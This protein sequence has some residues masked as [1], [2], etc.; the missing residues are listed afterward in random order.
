M[1][2][3]DRRFAF[4]RIRPHPVPVKLSRAK[5]WWLA[6]ALLVVLI[7]GFAWLHRRPKAMDQRLAR[8]RAAGL[9]A[10]LAE[11][12]AWYRAVPDAENAAPELLEAI[13]AW[14]HLDSNTPV[15]PANGSGHPNPGA[16]WL[17]SAGAELT[18]NA[19]PLAQIHAALERPRS[20]YP[21]NLQAGA[22]LSFSH[23]APAKQ[24]AQQL[25]SEARFA[26]E[27]GDPE[28]AATALLATLRT[29]R[30]LEEEPL[31]ISYLVRLADNAIAIDAT[32]AVISRGPLSESGLHRLQQAFVAAESTNHLA[33]AIA[34]E[35][36]LIL[37]ALNQP[38]LK[39]FTAFAAPGNSSPQLFPMIFARLYDL[40]GLKGD[41]LGFCLDRLDDLANG[42]ARPRSE[43]IAPQ[44][45]L[46]AQ[47]DSLSSWRGRLRPLSR[48]TLPAFVKVLGKDLRSVATLRCAQTALAIERWRLAH[49]GSLP[50][51]LNALVPEYLAAVPEDPMDGKPLKY[52]V[53][54]PGYVV[55]S[56]G[57]DGTD[58]GGKERVPGSGVTKGWDYTF[59]VA[60]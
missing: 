60:R 38:A 22:A 59:T 2:S 20:R 19:V 11:L 30:T 5:G 21:V 45:E 3:S 44:Q 51:S 15:L 46:Q 28:R 55:Y 40:S 36:C 14:R 50:P 57:E 52:R 58:D 12:D 29:A 53:L 35:R 31:L 33:R 7:A 34:G 24:V 1:I 32:Q 13:A 42:V 49:G 27:T 8:Y 9:P 4:R 39:M 25:A 23:L 6:A 43:A 41:D 10:T 18:S 56:L 47:I 16:A 48:Q 37:D 26:A 17:A 54:S